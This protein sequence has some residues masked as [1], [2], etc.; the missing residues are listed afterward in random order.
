MV[1]GPRKPEFPFTAV[2]GQ[3]S[4]KLALILASIDPSIGGVLI[5]G[6]RG[7]AK[8]TLARGLAD[9]QRGGPRGF[10]NLP[11]GATE[12]MLIGTLDLQHVLNKKE[13]D[14]SPGLLSK[15]HGGVLYVDEVN[16]LADP[17]VDLLLDVA[18]SGVNYIE[19]DGVSH[20]H[21]AEFQLL[22]TMNP[23]E[24]ELRPQLQDRF[25]LAVDLGNDY[26]SEERIA[27]VRQRLDFDRDP[28]AFCKRYEQSQNDLVKQVESAAK[29][30]PRVILGEE[31]ETAIATACLD[32]GVDGLRADI[33][34][35]KAAIAHTAWS[36]RS[37]VTQADVDAVEDLVLNHRRQE[38]NNSHNDLNSSPFSRPPNRHPSQNSADENQS[39][40]NEGDWGAMASVNQETGEL[41]ELDAKMHSVKRDK[42]RPR[43]AN[44]V[45]RSSGQATGY[46]RKIQ[47]ETDKVHWF[48]TLAA[49]MNRSA[50]P[51]KKWF[52]Q[53]PRG[54]TNT[55][56]LVLLDTSSS[57][58][59]GGLL[60][61][62]K[63]LVLG[64]AQQAYLA[65]QQIAIYC[66]GNQRLHCL[67]RLGRASRQLRRM[68][69]S[70]ECGGG[71]PLRQG[72]LKLAKLLRDLNHQ[73][74]GALSNSYIITDGRSTD[75]LN[76]ISLSGQVYWIDTECSSIR[77]GRGKQLARSI[78]AHY[79][80]M[81]V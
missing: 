32:A 17:L 44:T 60:A 2:I 61:N 38:P 6:P 71:T 36:G 19:R 12:E 65:R 37:H 18:A 42:L 51:P 31:I 4:L 20:H 21:A 55:V 57:T 34:W 10:V 62:A 74:P 23:D 41:L 13:V 64:I 49:S 77:R 67:Q 16:L 15:A 22:G 69:D 35:H 75:Q 53:R 47:G 9:L 72:V 33:C 46:Q 70:V 45:C 48:G 73:Y 25:A 66:F 63:G 59:R 8:S 54:A 52:Y 78:Q 79:C 3:T 27:I 14:F 30:L 56:H 39:E 81:P 11:L 76:G 43:S 5:S 1:T 29:Q 40:K 80:T 50:W 24:G 58:L 7:S 68:L 28:E 26:S